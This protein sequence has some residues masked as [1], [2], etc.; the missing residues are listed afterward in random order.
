[1]ELQGKIGVVTGVSKGIGL[2]LVK[3][4]L[5]KGAVVV[6][7]GRTEPQMEHD[8]FHFVSCDVGNE[9]SIQNAAQE[10]FERVGRD[11][12]FLVNNAGYGVYGNL[13]EQ[14]WSDWEGMFRVN[15]LGLFEVTRNLLPGMKALG[16]GHIVNISSIAGLNG[17]KGFSGYVGTKHA[18]RGISH[19][20]Y[21]ELRDFGIKVSTVYPGSVNTSFFDDIDMIEANENMMRPQDVAKSVVELLQ[22]HHNYFPVDLEIRPLKPRG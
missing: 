13:D 9:A 5:D 12:S 2:E 8:H 18:V 21:Q 14:S 4:L 7:W 22:T 16:Q 11:I 17:V 19:S 15:V 3:Q 20:W 6:G 1:M 10:T